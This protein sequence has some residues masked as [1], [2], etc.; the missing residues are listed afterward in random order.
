M[1]SMVTAHT[2][3]DPFNFSPAPPKEA[4]DRS[5]PSVA[6]LS[7]RMSQGYSKKS[8]GV[9]SVTM[10]FGDQ[11]FI[12]TATCGHCQKIMVVEPD[13]APSA[14]IVTQRQPPAV[15]H[16]CWTLVCPQ[17]H[18]KGTCTPWEAQ[19]EKIEARDRFLRSVGLAV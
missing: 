17:C 9:A 18:A 2:K 6:C 12:K 5:Y 14:M 10:P 1:G 15:C 7:L 16:R 4:G 19:M 13:A 11:S 8:E 3:G